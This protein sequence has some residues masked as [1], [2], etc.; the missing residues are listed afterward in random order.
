MSLDKV[1]LSSRRSNLLDSSLES[2]SNTING[3]LQSEWQV[4]SHG[5]KQGVINRAE[6][7]M[8]ASAVLGAACVKLSASEASL[9]NLTP[10][11]SAKSN[12]S[13]RI[14]E[15]ESVVPNRHVQLNFRVDPAQL[16]NYTLVNTR[17]WVTESNPEVVAF[18]NRAWELDQDAY[19]YLLN[20]YM[21]RAIVNKLPRDGSAESNRAWNLLDR[22]QEDLTFKP[23]LEQTQQTMEK[24][25]SEWESNLPKTQNMMQDMTGLPLDKTINVYITHPSIKAGYAG[26]GSVFW[27]D[28]SDFPNYNTVYLWHETLHN[29]I[30]PRIVGP[31]KYDVG[32]AVIELLADNE[33]RVKLNGGNMLPLEGHEYLTR[34]EEYLLPSWRAYVDKPGPKN[35]FQYIDQA[36]ALIGKMP[37]DA[38]GSSPSK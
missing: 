34:G 25:K 21:E 5:L 24:V 17:D 22:M 11:E 15:V 37:A 26:E 29:V 6:Q 32:H 28:R 33:L 7:M 18:Q 13:D 20:H 36:A 8:L 31:N 35:I 4:I 10:V 38:R 1:D 9:E 12:A 16:A 27:T 3:A 30:E 2:G 19:T 14:S 23:I